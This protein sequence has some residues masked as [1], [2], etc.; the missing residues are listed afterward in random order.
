MGQAVPAPEAPTSEGHGSLALTFHPSD[1]LV[2]IVRRFV[3]DV[4]DDVV[5]DRDAI[6]RVALA[7]HELLENAVKY[8]ASD[9]AEVSV[10]VSGDRLRRKVVV[11]TR[12]RAS[13]E[14][15]DAA[16][17][18]LDEL[19]AA[20]DAVA[21]YQQLIRRTAREHGSGLGLARVRAE[22][23]MAMRHVIEGETI[24]IQADLEVESRP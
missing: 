22:A 8:A 9:E 11:T 7:T 14:H 20:P 10:A 15:L 16:A 23:V 1:A 6:S 4:F 12:N 18:H 17:R 13:R 19:M 5:G 21:H 3:L 2:S 24:C